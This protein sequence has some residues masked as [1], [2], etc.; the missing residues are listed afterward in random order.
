[1]D[2]AKIGIHHLCA[3]H[4][5][6]MGFNC[7]WQ[8]GHKIPGNWDSEDSDKWQAGLARIS[9]RKKLQGTTRNDEI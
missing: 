3:A 6:E 4:L 5:T 9:D 1:M 8:A 2:Q 7:V